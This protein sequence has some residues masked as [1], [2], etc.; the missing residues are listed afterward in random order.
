MG[1]IKT[2]L[3]DAMQESHL[4]RQSTGQVVP[5]NIEAPGQGFYVGLGWFITTNF[6][7]EAIW[8]NGATIGGY[9]AYM[10]FNPTSERGI[11]I[12][13]STDILDI[14]ITTISFS[15]K[16]KLS[17]LLWNLLNP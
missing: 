6:G 9:N 4:I 15:Q 11:V 2:K 10:A 17:Y 7:H 12:L 14:N 5:N 3:N 16:D 13:C 8:H 1:L